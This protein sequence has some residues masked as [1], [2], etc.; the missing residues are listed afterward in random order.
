MGYFN[1]AFFTGFGFGPLLGGVLT[2][3]FWNDC[4]LLHYGWSWGY[5]FYAGC[6]SPD[7]RRGQEIRDGLNYRCI[8]HVN[9]YRYGYRANCIW[10]NS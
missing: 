8:Y 9:E 3:H 4:C 7:C 6:L 1:A 5:H 10:G 2:D